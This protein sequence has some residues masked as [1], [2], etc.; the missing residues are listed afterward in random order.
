ML[1]VPN[2][3]FFL[4]P[5]IW[6]HSFPYKYCRKMPGW[7]ELVVVPLRLSYDTHIHFNHF[8]LSVC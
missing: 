3:D 7:L 8:I 6:P 1:N 5:Q 2:Y 4:T